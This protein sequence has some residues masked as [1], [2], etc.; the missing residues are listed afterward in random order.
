MVPPSPKKDI[1]KPALG[2]AKEMTMPAAG[3]WYMDVPM[4]PRATKQRTSQK[5]GATPT[6]GMKMIVSSGPARMKR[7]VR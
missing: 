3:G 4:A 6:R 1:P 5:A 7:R 2:P